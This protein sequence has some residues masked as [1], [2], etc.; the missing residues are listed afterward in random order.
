MGHPLANPG[1]LVTLDWV[2]AAFLLA[3]VIFAVR[4]D[5]RAEKELKRWRDYMGGE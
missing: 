5:R 2:V 3:C 4:E 1:W